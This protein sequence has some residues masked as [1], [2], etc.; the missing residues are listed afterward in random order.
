MAVFKV[1]TFVNI[2]EDLLSMP[3]LCR[4][5]RMD[6][7]PEIGNS[8]LAHL[9]LMC[10]ARDGKQARLLLRERKWRGFGFLG[11]ELAV[12]FISARE[13]ESVRVKEVGRG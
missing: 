8:G 3:N 4:R 9:L 10:D 5:Q 12:D 11:V 6:F 13:S 1:P 7:E 2:L